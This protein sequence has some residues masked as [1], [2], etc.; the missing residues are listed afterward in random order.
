MGLLGRFWPSSKEDKESTTSSDN[1]A[2][3]F[4]EY[5]PENIRNNEFFQNLKDALPEDAIYSVETFLTDWSPPQLVTL[6]TFTIGAFGLGIMV[7]RT[8]AS[9]LRRITN[10]HT[11][12][13][14]GPESPILKGRV[15]KVSDGD[16]LRFY[17]APTMFHSMNPDPDTKLSDQTLAI[18]ICTIDTPEVAKFGK[19]SQP[20]GD[21]AKE[22]LSGLILD[23]RV[24]VRILERD[25]YGRAVATVAK[26][27]L[28]FGKTYCD[29]YMLKAGLAEV[30][31]GSGAVYGP[32]G[33]DYYL[34]LMEAA[35]SKK[36]GM[37]S[38]KDRET[39][40]EFKARMKQESI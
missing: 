38:Q 7:G 20:F 11:I 27:G 16:T 23:R 13:N 5:V 31:L 2:N 28:V 12:Q 3:T 15:L 33:K 40:A 4:P 8:G 10:V 9:S 36:K 32:K 39:A 24:Q 25:Q 30:Y 35:K 26:P 6:T 18:R 21:E 1:Y 17:H 22:Y 19:P 34:K 37:W 29:E 14:V